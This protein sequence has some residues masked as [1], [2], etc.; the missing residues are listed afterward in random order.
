MINLRR[1]G[2][3]VPRQVASAVLCYDEGLVV[4]NGSDA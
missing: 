4:P 2:M 1:R 3:L